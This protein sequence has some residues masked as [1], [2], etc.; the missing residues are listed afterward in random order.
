[1]QESFPAGK[2]HL[3]LILVL[4]GEGR[5]V[6]GKESMCLC[7]SL[8]Q[9]ARKCSRF[10]FILVLAQDTQSTT[11]WMPRNWRKKAISLKGRHTAIFSLLYIKGRVVILQN[12][13][14]Q[15]WRQSSYILR[16][17]WAQINF[18]GEKILLLSSSC[19]RRSQKVNQRTL[20]TNLW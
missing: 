5:V 6:K 17:A 19:Q 13:W 11:I 12:A 4:T 15:L 9:P 10:F 1:M 18:E 3:S 14:S 7:S 20:G 16:G 8:C 2:C